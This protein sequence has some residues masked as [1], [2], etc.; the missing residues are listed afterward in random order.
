MT[1]RSARSRLGFTLIELLVVIAII[2]ILIAL[3]VPAVQKVREAAARTQCVNNLK[4]IVLSSHNYHAA[5]KMLPPGGAGS[6][7]G[8]AQGTSNSDGLGIGTLVF[9]LPYLD[10]LP[11]YT[12]FT[13]AGGAAFVTPGSAG[14]WWEYYAMYS[15]SAS[16]C[17]AQLAVFQ[18][19][20]MPAPQA[21]LYGDAAFSGMCYYPPYAEWVMLMDYFATG[22]FNSFAPGQLLGRTSY[23][24]QSGYYGPAPGYPY[25]GPYYAGST[26]TMV[27][28]T[29]G[30]SNTLAFGESSGGFP[31]DY[32]NTWIGSGN[33]PL[34]WWPAATPKAAQWYQFSSYHPGIVNFAMCDGTVRAVGN[35]VNY[36]VLL[37]AA[38]MNDN[39][40]FNLDALNP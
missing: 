24:A 16:P 39:S 22:T 38:G 14:Y 13:N 32:A 35:N 5:W 37:E 20:S 9:L 33:L 27:Q 21:A 15:N 26:T 40:E 6:Q 17:Y 12:Q 23:V 10:Q 3:L 31:V 1:F 34:A 2:A 8:G 18:C 29:D 25:C 36:T 30:T 11:L 7:Y 28:I 4:N 19:P